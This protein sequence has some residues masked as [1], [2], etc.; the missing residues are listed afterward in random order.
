MLQTNNILGVL[1]VNVAPLKYML[2]VLI[3]NDICDTNTVLA[4]NDS[5]SRSE[6]TKYTKHKSMYIPGKS[7][8]VKLSST[9]LSS[10]SYL[11]RVYQ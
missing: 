8:S 3:Q 2:W 5:L 6:P 7:L 10:G 4:S 1:I 11:G 9:D